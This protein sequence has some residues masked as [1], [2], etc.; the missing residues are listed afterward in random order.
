MGYKVVLLCIHPSQSVLLRSSFTQRQSTSLRCKTLCTWP[1]AVYHL[2][3]PKLSIAGT[4]IGITLKGSQGSELSLLLQSSLMAK[5]EFRVPPP[6]D[7]WFSPTI[8]L[9]TCIQPEILPLFAYC[10]SQRRK[11]PIQQ[12]PAVVAERPKFFFLKEITTKRC[13]KSTSSG[14]VRHSSLRT[15]IDSGSR[16]EHCFLENRHPKWQSLQGSLPWEKPSPVTV[17]SSKRHFLEDRHH[18]WPPHQASPY[19]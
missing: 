18:K 3:L 12:G 2:Y 10:I 13:V 4:C 8:E 5:T 19:Q 7:H 15:A 9:C 16:I 11:C 6:V 14:Y 17:S 1:V